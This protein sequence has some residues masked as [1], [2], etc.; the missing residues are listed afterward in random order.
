MIPRIDLH[1]HTTASDGRFSPEEIVRKAAGLDLS[2]IAICDHDTVDGIAPALAAAKA[3]PTLKVIPGVEVSTLAPGNEVHML[4]YFIDCADPDLKTALGGLRNSRLERAEAIISKLKELGIDIDWRRVRELAGDGSVG[5]PH[6]ARAMLEK[7]YIA[8]FKEAFDKYIGLGGPAHVER[9][10]I[11]PSGA[12]ALITQA[13]G[14][15][16]LAHPLTVND[17]EAMIA[18]LKK[19]GL[20]GIEVYY[21]DYDEAK[22]DNLARLAKKYNLIATGGSDY[23]GMDDNAETMMGSAGVPFES[24]ERLTALARQRGLVSAN[25]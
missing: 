25:L 16:V 17:P 4:G 23:H 15:P 7:N 11:T 2:A 5:R 19:A 21:N 22:R 3:F 14:L 13:S 24:L 12:V 6:I 8:S 9:H 18:A 1:I 10:K 20:V